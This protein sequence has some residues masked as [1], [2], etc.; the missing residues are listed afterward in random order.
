LQDC[1]L[2]NAPNP[3][4]PGY[5]HRKQSFNINHFDLGQAILGFFAESVKLNEV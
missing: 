5:P 3:A 1:L 2:L 4:L